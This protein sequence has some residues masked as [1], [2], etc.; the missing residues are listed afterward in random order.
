MSSSLET[1][2]GKPTSSQLWC[3]SALNPVNSRVLYVCCTTK[4][5][6]AIFVLRNKISS[7]VGIGLDF[8]FY[9]FYCFSQQ[10]RIL[11]KMEEGRKM[12]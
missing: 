1:L 6:S 10:R 9:L 8:M 11:L 3:H 12:K 5:I 7:L 2:V 4:P